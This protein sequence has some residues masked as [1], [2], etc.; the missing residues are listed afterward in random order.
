M[1]VSASPLADFVTV[2]PLAIAGRY[3]VQRDKD[4]VEDARLVMRQTVLLVQ[5]HSGVELDLSLV[6]YSDSG[7][8][9]DLRRA[10]TVRCSSGAGSADADHSPNASAQHLR[11]DPGGG[12]GVAGGGGQ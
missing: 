3:V 8:F 2:Q 5:D 12:G 6:D 7:V 10:D 11:S 4:S 1:P 9:D